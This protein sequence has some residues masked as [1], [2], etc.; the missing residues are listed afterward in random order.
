MKLHTV[1]YV[2]LVDVVPDEAIR[3]HVLRI[4]GNSNGV[5]RLSL[6][7]VTKIAS[8]LA[9][10]KGWTPNTDRE[11]GLALKRLQALP[12]GVLINLE[13]M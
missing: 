6:T 13:V 3:K 10:V 12:Q 1:P 7:G 11:V 4:I 8:V 9:E 5:V 2:N